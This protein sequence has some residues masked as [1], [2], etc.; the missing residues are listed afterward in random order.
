LPGL[1]PHAPIAEIENVILGD[2]DHGTR[3]KPRGHG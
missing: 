1:P 2:T 3:S